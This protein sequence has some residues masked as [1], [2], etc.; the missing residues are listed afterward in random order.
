M[1]KKDDDEDDTVLD[2]NAIGQFRTTQH[3]NFCNHES[4]S[5]CDI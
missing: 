2:P 3:N 4:V 1:F 5:D